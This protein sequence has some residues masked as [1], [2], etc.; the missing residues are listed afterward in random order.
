[1]NLLGDWSHILQDELKKEYFIKLL[2]TI[3]N[4][5][6]AG[7]VIY[8]DDQDIFS[9]F[10]YTSFADVKVV[11]VG[12]DPYHG[13]GQAHGLAFSVK[14]GVKIPPSLKNILRELT[15]DLPTAFP[16]HGSLISWAKQGV[17]LLNS[18]LTVEE[19]KPHS[20]HNLGWE[21]FTDAV[22][23]ALAERK[24]PIVFLLWGKAA[25]KKAEAILLT[26]SHHRILHAA[27]PSPYSARGFFGCRHFSK[28]NEILKS[29]HKSPIDWSIG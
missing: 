20:H 19:K 8:P 12:Q 16:S 18:T 27:H 9:A 26:S 11:I 23:K 6:D 28:V 14:E 25:E 4:L 1:M 7:T 2:K 13:K 15:D 22:I 10:S 29:W 17:L 3:K 5:R 21:I 24:D